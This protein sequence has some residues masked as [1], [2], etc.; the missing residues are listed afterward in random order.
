MACLRANCCVLWACPAFGLC[1]RAGKAGRA[2]QRGLRDYAYK[3]LLTSLR[4]KFDGFKRHPTFALAV[5][6]GYPHLS[7]T[8]EGETLGS[9]CK[10]KEMLACAT[11]T[12]APLRRDFQALTVQSSASKL[13]LARDGRRGALLDLLGHVGHA[14]R[15]LRVARLARGPRLATVGG[16]VDAGR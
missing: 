2:R 6:T 3:R 11:P 1:A 9:F 8:R 13:R 5:T 4:G 12:P 14:H 16:D 15:V 7:H 10:L